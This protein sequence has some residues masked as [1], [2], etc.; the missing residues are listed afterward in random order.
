MNR[1]GL[2]VSIGRSLGPGVERR[3]LLRFAVG[4]VDQLRDET[5]TG[6]TFRFEIDAE[7][8]GPLTV[9][10]VSLSFARDGLVIRESNLD[11]FVATREVFRL[12]ER[13]AAE[14]M[15]VVFAWEPG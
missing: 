7:P 10:V 3:E 13:R 11:P 4:L 2:D 8:S 12:A 1:A 6:E 5:G 14:R 9:Y 15:S